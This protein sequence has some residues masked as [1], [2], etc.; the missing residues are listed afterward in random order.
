MGV[1]VSYDV[2]GQGTVISLNL[3]VLCYPCF[4]ALL[5]SPALSQVEEAVPERDSSPR[6][7]SRGLTGSQ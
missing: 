5:S 2:V 7:G 1:D 3:C 4:H 6:E